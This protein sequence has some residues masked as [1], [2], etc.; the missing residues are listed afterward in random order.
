MTQIIYNQSDNRTF[1][2]KEW[3]LYIRQGYIIGCILM[4]SI[5]RNNLPSKKGIFTIFTSIFLSIYLHANV[6]ILYSNMA[7]SFLLCLVLSNWHWCLRINVVI[8]LVVEYT[9]G[10]WKPLL[11]A[12]LFIFN[13]VVF[14][15]Q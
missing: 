3:M 2:M 10:V 7:L 8:L 13:C 1:V 12:V 15:Y 4:L 5:A 6:D 9:C 14:F 11:P